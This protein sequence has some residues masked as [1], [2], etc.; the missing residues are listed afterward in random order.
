M[1]FMQRFSMCQINSLGYDGFPVKVGEVLNWNGRI[2]Q[3]PRSMLTDLTVKAHLQ[4]AG[5]YILFFEDDSFYIGETTCVYDR[6]KAHARKDWISITVITTKSN[7]FTEDH[8][9][10]L[11]KK[12]CAYLLRFPNFKTLNKKFSDSKGNGS[13]KNMGGIDDFFAI[14]T[15]LLNEINPKFNRSILSDDRGRYYITSK[16]GTEAVA[17]YIDDTFTVLKG[18][19][20]PV[21]HANSL[22]DSQKKYRDDIIAKY[23]IKINGNYVLKE[24]II[25]NSC[26]AAAVL[27]L[28]YN[29]NG[30]ATWRTSNGISIDDYNQLQV[31]RQVNI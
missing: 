2:L 15:D 14:S 24:N 26:S 6:L 21:N 10:Y 27:V 31:R 4:H 23:T 20:I 3:I 12:Y 7:E 5:I 18:S 8:L 13:T 19:I 11:E 17:Q 25:T 22:S 16:K 1:M 29:V 9:K 30:L 28:G